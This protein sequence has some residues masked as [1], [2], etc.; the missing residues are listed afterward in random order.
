MAKVSLFIDQ[1][2]QNQAATVTLVP[3]P[4]ISSDPIDALIENDFGFAMTAIYQDLGDAHIS[5][6]LS[7]LASTASNMFAREQRLFKTTQSTI[8]MYNG[9]AKPIFALPITLLSYKRDKSILD[10][11]QTLI[12]GVA[13]TFNSTSET[14]EDFNIDTGDALDGANPDF[15]MKAPGGYTTPFAD[16]SSGEFSQ[17]YNRKKLIDGISGTWSIRYSTWF[18]AQKLVMVDCFPTISKE[19]MQDTG[20]P[21]Y[22][23][24][25]LVFQPSYLPDSNDVKSWFRKSSATIGNTDTSRKDLLGSFGKI[26]S[27]VD[28]YVGDANNVVST[29][30]GFLRG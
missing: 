30:K 18:Q 21:L 29:V 27:D 28:R 14:L 22:A 6:V 7:K 24:I 15:F 26:M 23:K 2:M 13:P 16:I 12:T 11:V 3:P 20:E 19:T 10:T 8:S 9:S 25:N 5:D 4:D 17:L 1:L